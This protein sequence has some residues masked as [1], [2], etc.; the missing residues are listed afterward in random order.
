MNSGTQLPQKHTYIILITVSVLILSLSLDT[1][2]RVKDLA[3]YD[4]WYKD[5]AKEIGY[6]FEDAFSIYVTA[7]ISAYFFNVVIPMAF[8]I[9][10]YLAYRKIRINSLFVFIWVV[11]LIGGALYV[12]TTFALGSIFYYI[13]IVGYVVLIITILSLMSVISETKKR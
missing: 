9:H 11:L 12:V 4:L 10:T 3:L 8:G 2:M 1:L 5:M 7:N 13:N 6:S